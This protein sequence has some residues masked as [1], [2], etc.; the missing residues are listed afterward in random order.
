MRLRPL[1]WLFLSACL[2][3]GWPA[4]SEELA[5]ADFLAEVRRPLRTNA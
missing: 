4:L 5:P 1:L 3:W 2:L